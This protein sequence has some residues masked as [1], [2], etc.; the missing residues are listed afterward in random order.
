MSIFFY[1]RRHPEK[2]RPFR[3]P[4]YPWT[5]LLFILS[6][7]AIVVNTMISQPGRALV[8]I[9]IVLLGAPAF[10]IWRARLQRQKVIGA[11]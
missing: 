3:V 11:I 1:R 9:A 6:A 8:G 2:L 7:A 4:G 10:F 5:P